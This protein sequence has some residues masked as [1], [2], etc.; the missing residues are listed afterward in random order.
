MSVDPYWEAILYIEKG[1]WESAHQLIK[2]YNTE[3]ACWIHAH[4]HRAEGDLWNANYWY[5]RAGKQPLTCTLN[6]EQ[7][8]I[9]SYLLKETGK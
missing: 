6:E 2:R 4:L 8:K 3:T 7:D 9:K 1:D 5:E